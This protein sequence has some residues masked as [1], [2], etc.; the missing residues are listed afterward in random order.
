[1]QMVRTVATT[2]VNTKTAVAV[3]ESAKDAQGIESVKKFTV[4]LPTTLS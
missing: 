1:M 2:A 4:I 3:Q